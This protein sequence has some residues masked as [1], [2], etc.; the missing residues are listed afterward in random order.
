MHSLCDARARS[1]TIAGAKAANIAEAAAA[2]FPTV[3]GFVIT[4]A[5][6]AAGLEDEGVSR[7]CVAPTT[8]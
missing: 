8:T 5:A 6:I 7:R 4:T 1:A 3:P 2:G